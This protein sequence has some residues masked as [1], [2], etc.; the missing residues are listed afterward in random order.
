MSLYTRTA[1]LLRN[2]VMQTSSAT[3]EKSRDEKCV[4]Q[5]ILNELEEE[6]AIEQLL[7]EILVIARVLFKNRIS[8]LSLYSLFYTDIIIPGT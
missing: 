6:A 5:V 4:L 3:S 7:S 8:F 1:S 2:N